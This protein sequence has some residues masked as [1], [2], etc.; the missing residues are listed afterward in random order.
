MRLLTPTRMLTH[1]TNTKV[2]ANGWRRG[3]RRKGRFTCVYNHTGKHGE[4]KNGNATCAINLEETRI[5]LC[6]Q[7]DG[8]GGTHSQ[9]DLF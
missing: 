6:I 1:T 7:K 5:D 4:D 8:Q 2:D 3:R 9:H